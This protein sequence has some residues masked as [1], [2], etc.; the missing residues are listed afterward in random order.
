MTVCREPVGRVWTHRYRDRE[1]TEHG[2]EHRPEQKQKKKQN[3][4]LR[5]PEKLAGVICV[6]WL[7]N[8]AEPRAN[9]GASNSQPE[10]LTRFQ[11]GGFNQNC[12]RVLHLIGQVVHLF[13]PLHHPVMKHRK[14]GSSMESGALF[15]VR[16]QWCE[17]HRHRVGSSM[18]ICGRRYLEQPAPGC[19]GSRLPVSNAIAK[20]DSDSDPATLIEHCLRFL[21]GTFGSP[22]ALSGERH[23]QNDKFHYPAVRGF[24]V[25]SKR[26]PVR[27]GIVPGAVICPVGPTENS[28]GTVGERI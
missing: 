5:Q 11:V 27:A 4:D 20:R 6:A 25:P 1:G 28:G 2:P 17:Q 24:T 13:H 7:R 12:H 26:K 19:L 10:S 8:E 18:R 9:A 14:P 23:F 21:Q 16:V 15:V 22:R 3:L